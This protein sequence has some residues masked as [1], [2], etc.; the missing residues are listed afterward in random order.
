[1]ACWMLACQPC[2]A[3]TNLAPLRMD[4]LLRPAAS[5]TITANSTGNN[6]T[7][8]VQP[9]NHSQA[10]AACQAIGGHLASFL[11]RDEQLDVEGQLYSTGYLLPS[12]HRQYWLGLTSSEDTWPTFR[13][14]CCASC[15][16]AVAGMH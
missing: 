5:V 13:C 15:C 4:R 14:V 6:Y 11:S 7:L 10:E 12:F 3:V 2:L 16:T 9:L 1:M 8:R